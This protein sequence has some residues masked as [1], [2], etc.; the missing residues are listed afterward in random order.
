MKQFNWEK[1]VLLILLL[2]AIIFLPQHC[3]AQEKEPVRYDT[4]AIDYSNIL[5]TFTKVSS[6]GKTVK[7]Y[8][9]YSYKGVKD[10]TNISK[11]VIQY[12]S[13]CEE[14][15]IEPQLA[16]KLKDGEVISVIKAKARRKW[17]E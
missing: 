1:A 14:A 13:M 17:K 3:N 15:G 9:V 2:A 8:C 10:L 7:M 6:S 16:L 12:I 11:S 4:I 5:K